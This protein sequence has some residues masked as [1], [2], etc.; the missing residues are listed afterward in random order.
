MGREGYRS[1]YGDL[2][3]LKDNSLLADPAGGTGDDD[4]LWQTLLSATE[5]ADRYC[6][7]IFYPLTT[8]R[9]FSGDGS[10]QLLLPDL[11]AV[12]TLKEDTN[13]DKTFDTTWATTD[14]WTQP[15]DAEPTKHWGRAYDKVTIRAQGT[16]SGFPSA[17]DRNFEIVGQWGYRNYTEASGT[18]VNNGAGYSAS[19]TSI[20]VDDGT[21]LAIGQTI[22]IGTEQLLV[23]NISS[24]TLTVVRG[25]NGTTA[26][27]IT[28]NDPVSI[29][30]WPPDLERAV[31]IQ[32]ARLWSRAPTFEPFYVDADLDTDVRMLLD[33]YRRPTV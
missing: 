18:L 30:R 16:K 14:Y 32:T 5:W 25:L 28:D 2:T 23:T 33:A 12:T 13:G 9:Y 24:N 31:L 10:K 17:Y 11:L 21:E 4:E 3:K 26:A 27:T 19:A 22:I 7:R 29:L 6:N 8:T 1:L 15:F 20:V